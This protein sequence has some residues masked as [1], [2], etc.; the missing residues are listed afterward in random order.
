MAPPETSFWEK[1]NGRRRR[2]V[3]A[4]HL[5]ALFLPFVVMQA[6][7]W[8]MLGRDFTRNPV[9][10]EKNPPLEW[11]IKTGRNIKWRASLGYNV[12]ADPIVAGG[13][14]WAGTGN[15]NPADPA[16]VGEA[17][18]L[19]CFRETDG[20]LL[21]QYV[22]SSKRGLPYPL[23]SLGWSSSPLAEGPHL[24]FTTVHGEV[25]CLEVEPLRQGERMPRRVWRTDMVEKFNVFPQYRSMSGGKTCSI[26]A[27]YRNLIYVI[28]GNG[29]AGWIDNQWSDK[30]RSPEAP[31]LICFDKRT[32][33]A[34]WKD[35][36]PGT[37]ILFSQWGSPLVVEIGGRGQVIAPQGDG[38][39]RSFDA[40]S[41]ELL[42]KLDMNP[43]AVT[44]RYER[45]QFL[46]APVYYQNHIF[47]GAGLD[48]EAG[49]GP[50]A[51]VCIDPAGR[52]DRS[53][54]IDD[55]PGKG[56]PNPNSGV[57]WHF[58]Q[59]GR[60]TSLVAIHNGLVIAAGFDGYLHCL[61]AATGQPYWR[62]DMK[63]RVFGSP[64]IVDGKV[65]VADEDGSV[66]I[67][68]LSKTKKLFFEHD[69]KSFMA[70]SPIFANGVL[71]LATSQFLYAIEQGR[72]TPP[73]PDAPS[74]K[75]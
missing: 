10:P 33:E 24:W 74:L 34:V 53:L 29:V 51:L 9:S 6:D 36:S 59:L 64:L 46:T 37:N 18:V 35:N 60:T 30:V 23:L 31:S 40:L 1:S 45:N 65:Y 48:M 55:G 5:T 49:D 4:L 27:S 11:D 62:H 71:Y 38:W 22:A 57:V 44:K 7:D 39:V 19:K 32:G 50:G 20:Q 28:T 16:V 63:A 42:W 2:K 67:L 3:S 47:I 54:E 43:K 25:H 72:F 68:E 12:F 15:E 73:P 41:G 14:V 61:D 58:D 52:G 56:K 26:A 69:M 21:Y 75:K 66:R 8:P 17:A 70:S 13:L